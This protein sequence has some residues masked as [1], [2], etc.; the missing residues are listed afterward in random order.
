MGLKRPVPAHA[1]KGANFMNEQIDL[2]VSMG[3]ALILQT[4]KSVIKNPEKKE[5]LKRGMVKLRD[6]LLIAYPVEE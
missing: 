5:Q 4:L 6:Q 1:K 2:L 3:M